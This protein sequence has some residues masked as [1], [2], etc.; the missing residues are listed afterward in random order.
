MMAGGNFKVVFGPHKGNREDGDG[1]DS[2]NKA[3][4]G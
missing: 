2:V 1:G 4:G 3:P